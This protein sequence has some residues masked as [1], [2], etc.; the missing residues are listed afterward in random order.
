MKDIDEKKIIIS[1]DFRFF[2]VFDLVLSLGMIK[3]KVVYWAYDKKK[4]GDLICNWIP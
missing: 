1:K 4:Q 2:M 3:I